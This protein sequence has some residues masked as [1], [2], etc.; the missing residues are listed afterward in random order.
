MNI[1]EASILAKKVV[2]GVSQHII[3]KNQVLRKVMITLLADGHILWEDY[4]GLAKTLIS[5]LFS[6]AIG[7][8]FKR[9]QFTP[10]LLPADIT[11]SYIYNMEKQSFEFR[12]GPLFANFV[13]GDEINRAPPKTQSAILESMQEYQITIEGNRFSLDRPF[14][15]VATQ[16]PIEF[17]GTFGLPEA[18]LDRFMT[19]L[20]V[21]Y[22]SK[23]EERTI[24][25]KRI[26]RKTKEVSVEPILN[27]EQFLK[28]QKL[29][30]EIHVDKEIL[31]YIINIVNKTRY[32][33][34][35]TVGA[36]VR[37]SEALLSIARATALYEG[38]DFVITEDVKNSVV[39][40]LAH[41]VIVKTGD[42]LGGFTAEKIIVDVVSSIT[43][44]RKVSLMEE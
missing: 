19:R 30:E 40:C 25:E 34:K 28:M 9:I 13:L 12:K 27:K 39:E 6:Q 38:R 20:R 10:D 26:S 8:E 1:K 35:L 44:P 32:H 22:P 36:S 24:L 37:G 31:Q 43:T 21:G 16:N 5:N 23:E 3:G 11:G 7:L 33:N 18:Q 15:V 2:T 14:I 42:W 29:V 4:P 17:E 41:R